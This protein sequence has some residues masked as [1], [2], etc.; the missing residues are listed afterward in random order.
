MHRL[1]AERK[2]AL[3]TDERIVV[4]W[5]RDFYGVVWGRERFRNTPGDEGRCCEPGGY[6]PDVIRELHLVYCVRSAQAASP[7]RHTDQELT[8]AARGSR[9]VVR[10]FLK[11]PATRFPKILLDKRTKIV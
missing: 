6:L 8:P 3:A 7:R 2:Q 11:S 10:E 1:E 4:D 9:S 5:Y